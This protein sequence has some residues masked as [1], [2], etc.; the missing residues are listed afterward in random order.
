[1]STFTFGA[2]RGVRFLVAA[3]GAFDLAPADAPAPA[4]RPASQPA[5]EPCVRDAP[6]AVGRALGAGV[7]ALRLVLRPSCY[8]LNV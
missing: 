4:R 7:L 2:F 8:T 1:M 3:V 5:G 6:T